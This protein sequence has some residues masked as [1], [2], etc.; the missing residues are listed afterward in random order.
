MANPITMQNIQQHQFQDL[1]LNN[2][3]R[4]NPQQFPIKMIKNRPLICWRN[5]MNDPEGLWKI[6]LPSALVASVAPGLH[7]VCTQFRCEDCQLNKQI[8]A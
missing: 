4:Q 1:P 7:R 6:A 2:L 3:R 8:G 5:N